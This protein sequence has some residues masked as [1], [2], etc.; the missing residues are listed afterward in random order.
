MAL[1]HQRV[2]RVLQPARASGRDAPGR[3][4]AGGWGPPRRPAAYPAR[5][6]A[7]HHRCV[8]GWPCDPAAL[9]LDALTEALAPCAGPRRTLSWSTA[10]EKCLRCAL[11]AASSGGVWRDC[12]YVI[13]FV[14]QQAVEKPVT[15]PLTESVRSAQRE[16][17]SLR[18]RCTRLAVRLHQ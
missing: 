8:A 5:N 12:A 17:T 4:A 1:H 3:V 9:L 13:T 14:K 11:L 16:T 6:P 10:S 7:R 18:S 2:G 15:R